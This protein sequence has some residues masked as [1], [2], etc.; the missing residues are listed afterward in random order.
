MQAR[1]RRHPEFNRQILAEA[2]EAKREA[3]FKI[4]AGKISTFRV[5]QNR[6]HRLPK[7]HFP[8]FYVEYDVG[9]DR[10]GGRGSYRLVLYVRKHR[11]KYRV[12]K[13]YLTRDHYKHFV[14]I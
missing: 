9:T 3:S 10:V 5:Y 7:A 12:L 1:N 13:A 6:G 2:R 14:Q 11:G 4:A 8:N